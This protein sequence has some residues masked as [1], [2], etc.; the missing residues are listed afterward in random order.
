MNKEKLAELNK[1]VED[2]MLLSLPGQPKIMHVGTS[3]LVNDLWITVKDLYEKL[4]QEVL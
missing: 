4:D 2:F 1:R 3:S